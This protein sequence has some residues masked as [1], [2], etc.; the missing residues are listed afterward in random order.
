MKKTELIN[1]IAELDIFTSKA[2]AGRTFT[3]IINIIKQELIAGN[4]VIIGQDFGTFKIAQQAAKTGVIPGQ[5]GKTYSSPAKSVVKFK[6]SSQ[7]KA[8]VA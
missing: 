7:L 8:A 2:E 6:P 4:E 1:R 3:D 5:P